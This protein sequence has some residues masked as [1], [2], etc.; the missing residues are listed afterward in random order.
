MVSLCGFPNVFV[1]L[2]KYISL[3]KKGCPY[4]LSYKINTCKLFDIMN[5]AAY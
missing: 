1:K 2:Y 3:L 4:H 5:Y